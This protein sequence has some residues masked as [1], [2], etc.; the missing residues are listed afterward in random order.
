MLLRGLHGVGRDDLAHAIG[1]NHVEN[2][3]AA[4]GRTGT[5]WENYAPDRVGSGCSAPDFVGWS[6]LPPVAVLFEDV[7][8]LQT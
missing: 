6:G 2:V 1:R 8:G 7:F 3:A 4:F 5:L